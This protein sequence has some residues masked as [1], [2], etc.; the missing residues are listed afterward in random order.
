M[1]SVNPRTINVTTSVKNRIP[2]GLLLGKNAIPNAPNAGR[3][4]TAL[5]KIKMKFDSIILTGQSVIPEETYQDEKR[6]RGDHNKQHVL[7]ELSRL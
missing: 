7:T 1:N 2:S 3:K 6:Y 5:I 4:T